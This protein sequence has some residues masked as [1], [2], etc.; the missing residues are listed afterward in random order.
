MLIHITT[1]VWGERHIEVMSQVMWPSL[2]APLN[3]RALADKFEVTYRVATRDR[4]VDAIR[5]LPL[6]NQLASIVNVDVISI[7]N[8]EF[9]DIE[10][11]VEWYHRAISEAQS[12]NALV[13]FLPPDVIWSNCTLGNMARGMA[14]GWEACAMP[15]L[16]VITET[17]IPYLNTQVDEETGILDLQPRKL[18]RV[19]REHLHPL[20]AAIITKSPHSRPSLEMM[21]DI[22][23][24]GFLLRHVVRELFAFNP[25]NVDITHL[26]YAGGGV[27]SERIHVVDD[28]DEM[29]M[30]S[31]APY[32]KDLPIYVHNHQ[33][34]AFDVAMSSLHDWN[35]TPYSGH[36][37]RH[38]VRLH[39]AACTP[40]R[41]RRATFES[42]ITFKEVVV[43]REAMQV[44]DA[45]KDIGGCD[46]I[47]KL[48][49][50]AMYCT[51]LLRRWPHDGPC[52]FLVPTDVAFDAYS[53]WDLIKTGNEAQLVD[54]LLSLAVP[55]VHQSQDSNFELFCGEEA[56]TSQKDQP[57]PVG[58]HQAYILNRLPMELPV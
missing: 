58:R 46:I 29:M 41:W 21:W 10:L 1:C 11:H 33:I 34:D 47:C 43:A 18:M 51:D 7:S 25:Q 53:P 32:M 19:A 15:Y 13:A 52:T 12:V 9:P 23:G 22:P 39:E 57:I 37:A 14:S 56:Q 49:A 44:R 2:L 4:D 3:L 54:W 27:D 45:L 36:F 40:S 31:C 5:A 6:F 50:S 17:V 16:R 8:E 55:R 28:S 42:A 20:S 35:D 24:E 38:A 26:W 30:M 48:I